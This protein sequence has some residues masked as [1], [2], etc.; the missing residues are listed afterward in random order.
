VLTGNRS[1]TITRVAFAS[2]HGGLCMTDEHCMWGTA[3][4][5]AASNTYNIDGRT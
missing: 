1:T 2:S 5:D 4:N 3:A